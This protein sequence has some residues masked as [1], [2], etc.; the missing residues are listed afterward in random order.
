MRPA[1]RG[2]DEANLCAIRRS[3]ALWRPLDHPV[4]HLLP[5]FL[6]AHFP[7]LPFHILSHNHML[8]CDSF[9]LRLVAPSRVQQTVVATRDRARMHRLLQ[10]TRVD[11]LAVRELHG[12]RR[13]VVPRPCLRIWWRLLLLLLIC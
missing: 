11:Y 3:Y 4:D 5:L 10:L 9:I 6:A 2:H 12:L 1:L 8:V 7:I 13:P